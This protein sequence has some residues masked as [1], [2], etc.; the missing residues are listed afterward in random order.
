MGYPWFER[1]YTSFD[2]DNDKI[3][4]ATKYDFVPEEI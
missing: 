1:F 4:I 2:Y 3:K